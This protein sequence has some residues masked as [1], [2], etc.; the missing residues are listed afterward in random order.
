M[1]LL[2]CSKIYTASELSSVDHN[3]LMSMVYIL[4]AEGIRFNFWSPDRERLLTKVVE[5]CFVHTMLREMNQDEPV[6]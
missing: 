3:S 5:N 4:V 2:C 1:D 6:I